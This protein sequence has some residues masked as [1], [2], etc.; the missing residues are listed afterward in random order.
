MGWDFYTY[1]KQPQS[2]LEEILIIMKQ[3]AENEKRENK[4]LEQK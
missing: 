3:E 4:K 2:F 1:L